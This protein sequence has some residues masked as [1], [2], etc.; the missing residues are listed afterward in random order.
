MRKEA[1]IAVIV[2]M[3]VA[4]VAAVVVFGN[5]RAEMSADQLRQR[6]YG[7]RNIQEKLDQINKRLL[8]LADQMDALDERLSEQE[9]AQGGLRTRL[10]RLTKRLDALEKKLASVSK[11]TATSG[12][13]SSTASLPA[14]LSN[15]TPEQ[16]KAFE[17]LVGRTMFSLGM[18]YARRFKDQFLQNA[19]KQVDTVYAEKLDLTEMQKGDIKRILKEQ[20]NEGLKRMLELFQQGRLTEMAVVGRKLLSTTYERIKKVLEPDQIEKWKRIDERFRRYEE[21]VRKRRGGGKKGK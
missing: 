15:L 19:Y 13:T 7:L 18:R 20:A 1:L 3:A 14:D 12:K 17:R 10:F 5:P 2:V 9:D 8:V 21:S 11:V 6:R 16:Q 4:A